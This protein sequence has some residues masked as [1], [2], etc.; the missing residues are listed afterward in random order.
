MKREST[1]GDGRREMHSRTLRDLR[2]SHGGS[3]Y[4][5]YLVIAL[6]AGILIAKIIGP[7][8]GGAIVTEYSERRAILYSTTP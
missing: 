4:V 7:K 6:F 8:V 2:T 3:V 5:E 1:P